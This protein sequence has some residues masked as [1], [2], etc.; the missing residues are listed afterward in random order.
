MCLDGGGT[1]A[2][3][4][5]LQFGSPVKTDEPW[6]F[7][8]SQERM[9]G[10]HI[11][12]EI[13]KAQPSKDH[14][15]ACVTVRGVQCCYLPGLSSASSAQHSKICRGKAFPAVGQEGSSS[16]CDISAS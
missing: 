5:A 7:M 6:S 15:E 12:A 13:I 3:V 9:L 16:P 2:S 14:P 10:G 8:L 4:L 11:T 1:V